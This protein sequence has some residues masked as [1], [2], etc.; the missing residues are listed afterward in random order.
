MWFK[1]H[2]WAVPGAAAGIFQKVDKRRSLPYGRRKSLSFKLFSTQ[3][4]NEE[5]KDKEKAR[6]SFF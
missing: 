1:G 6:A 5:Y 4:I 3:C 2:E